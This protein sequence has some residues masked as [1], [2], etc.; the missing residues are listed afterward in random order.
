MSIVP[1]GIC[2]P[3]VPPTEMP[4]RSAPLAPRRPRGANV[5]L[6]LLCAAQFMVMLDMAIVNVALPSMQKSLH[7]SG[8]GLVWVV[9]AYTVVFGGFL[10]LGGRLADGYG[11]RR[12]FLGGV[13]LFTAS[14]LGCGVARSG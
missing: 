9:N 4:V 6:G 1:A 13:A 14:S 7:F 3:G 12:T 5:S 10:L 2:A 8:G 11:R